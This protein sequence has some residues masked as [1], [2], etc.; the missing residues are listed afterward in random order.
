MAIYYS[1]LYGTQS[2]TAAAV[3]YVVTLYDVDLL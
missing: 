2:P 3:I 1:T